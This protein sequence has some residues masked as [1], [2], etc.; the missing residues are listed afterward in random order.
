MFRK[1]MFLMLCILFPVAESAAHEIVSLNLYYSDERGDNFSVVSAQG[2][3][4][5]KA[6]GYRFVRHQGCIYTSRTP[7]TV[8]LRLYYHPGRGDNFSTASKK[9][10]LDAQAAGYRFVRVQGYVYPTRNQQTKPLE[11]FWSSARGDNFS[12]TKPGFGAARRANYDQVRTEGF[13]MSNASCK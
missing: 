11:L 13:V 12:A 5:A 10:A 8:A 3:A 4:A 9:G 2:V 6:A 7:T 1:I